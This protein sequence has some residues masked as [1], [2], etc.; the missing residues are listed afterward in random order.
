[1]ISMGEHY[2]G[3]E[4]SRSRIGQLLKCAS[5]SIA[6]ATGPIIGTDDFGP[7]ASCP[8]EGP[9]FRV[10]SAP[11]LNV[12]FYVSGSLGDFDITKIEASRFSRKQKLL[13]VAVPVPKEVVESGGSVEFVISALH[14]A[15]RIAAET[16]S[17]KGTEPF[18]F[19]KSES[20]VEKVKQKLVDQGF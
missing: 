1:M 11:A 14:E 3:P 19:A 6:E 4:L 9:Y 12:V 7:C 18:D 5:R 17:R 13:L 15:N 16:F 2:R 10:G 8:E 20:I